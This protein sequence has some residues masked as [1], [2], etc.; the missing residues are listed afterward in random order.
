MANCKRVRIGAHTKTI[1]RNRKGQIVR[2]ARSGM[3]CPKTWRGRKVRRT[4]NK[5]CYVVTAKGGR[6]FVKKVRRA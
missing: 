5:A 1:C 4:K 2:G 6:R 3:V